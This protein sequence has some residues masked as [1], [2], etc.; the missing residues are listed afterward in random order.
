M[1]ASMKRRRSKPSRAAR[2]AP[3]RARSG[4]DSTASDAALAGGPEEELVE[5]EAEIALARAAVDDDRVAEPAEHVVEGGREEPG[6]VVHLLELAQAVRVEV[7]RAREE[8][9][10]LQE[11]RGRSREELAADGLSFD[12][13]AHGG[14]L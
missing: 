3:A 1:G 12:L 10:L 2:S 5:D 8:V 11:L 14:V 4:R 9:Q 13:A 6:E 7:A